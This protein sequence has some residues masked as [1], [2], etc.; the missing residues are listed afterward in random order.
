MEHYTAIS[1][2]IRWSTFLK[3]AN[4]TVFKLQMKRRERS[5]IIQVPELVIEISI[6]IV[7]DLDHPVLYAKS[8]SE[9]DI[10]RMVMNFYH[11]VVYILPIKKRYRGAFLRGFFCAS[12]P[13]ENIRTKWQNTMIVIFTVKLFYL[14]FSL[15]DSKLG[16]AAGWLHS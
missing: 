16:I 7:P 2:R 14:G 6:L 1:Q 10:N 3:L 12:Q 9:I 11:P 13:I 5:F 15:G 4:K 8:I